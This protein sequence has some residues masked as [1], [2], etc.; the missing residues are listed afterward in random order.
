MATN[1]RGVSERTRR[2]IQ[3]RDRERETTLTRA[4]ESRTSLYE[5]AGAVV[6]DRANCRARA[7]QQHKF[8]EAVNTVARA[9]SILRKA[10]YT[11]R[12]AEQ[13]KRNTE[14]L[15]TQLQEFE[16]ILMEKYHNNTKYLGQELKN[17]T[18]KL[19]KL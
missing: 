5:Q 15:K 3:S 8:A 12:R 17:L 2:I 6:Q 14:S 19:N 16:T 13:S 9:T 1:K 10:V 4:R 7:T 18:D 11:T